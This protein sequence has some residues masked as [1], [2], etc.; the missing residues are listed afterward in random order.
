MS[1]EPPEGGVSEGAV[2]A[3]RPARTVP[4]PSARSSAPDLEGPPPIDQILSS[5]PSEAPPS[6]VPDSGSGAA[7]RRSRRTVRSPT[8]PFRTPRPRRLR[9]RP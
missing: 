4:R 9:L 7:R 6:G 5:H 3:P 1:G 8:T 2:E